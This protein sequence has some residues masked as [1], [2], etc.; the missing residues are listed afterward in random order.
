MAPLQTETD[1][2]CRKIHTII[3]V[4]SAGESTVCDQHTGL[5]NDSSVALYQRII[6]CCFTEMSRLPV[7][8]IVKTDLNSEDIK[9]IKSSCKTQHLAADSVRKPAAAGHSVFF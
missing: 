2:V 4:A 1:M 7:N 8:I 6:I 5:F 3:G 9:I